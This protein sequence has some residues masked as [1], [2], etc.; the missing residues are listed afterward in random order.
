MP[1]LNRRSSYNNFILIFVFV[2]IALNLLAI[3]RFGFHRDELL[4][5]ALADYMDWGYKEVPPFIAFIAKTTLTIFGDSVFGARIIPTM[6]AALIV[7]LTGKLT[8]EMGGKKFAIALA[9]SAMIFSPSFASTGYLFQPVVFDQLWW[10]LL[11]W[12][13][14]R[15][16]NNDS[17]PKYLYFIGLV[18]G[19]GL[20]TK[21]TMAFFAGSVILGLLFTK[22]RRLL[23]N[24]HVIGA[25]ALALLI[26]LPNLIWQ[27]HH[28]WPV[29]GHM[30]EL[31]KT[32]L[33]F[34]QP[35]DFTKQQLMAHG[36]AVILWITG[37]FFLL[38][39]FKLR[40]FQFLGFAYLLI[41]L[42]LMEM[43]GKNYYL[44]GA[45]PMLFAAGG[46]GFDRWVKTV[47]TLRVAILLAFI[48]PNLILL[49]I[50]LP[51]LSFKRTLG[52]FDYINKHTE[53]LKS[54]TVWEDQQ[55]HAT[56]QDY[57]DMLGWDEMTKKVADNYNT[58]S[59]EKQRETIIYTTNYGEAGALRHL[60][61][62][63]NLPQ[64]VSLASS[65]A[66][67]APPDITA[68]YIIYVSDTGDEDMV[69]YRS[70][71]K[72]HIKLDSV[73]NTYAREKGTD[74]YLLE[75]KP[76]FYERYRQRF[77]KAQIW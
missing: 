22:Q 50:V 18:I 9:C 39:S 72:G 36:I 7:W 65:F 73:T 19:V 51:I 17:S 28:S 34:I 25:A 12:L 55:H 67:W 46:F 70:M 33:N 31:K 38:R 48:I 13:M 49:P 54:V 63:Y 43:N 37:L 57:A 11:V 30:A 35:L 68:R 62:Q 52:F 29:F 27:Y 56:T 58:F 64:S 40:K 23:W 6:C 76:E 60:G 4:H 2:K 42:F 74:I 71:L 8:V 24:K 26:F 47:L 77:I 69:Y 21:Y 53:V 75:P 1:Y 45:Y 20:L 3:S 15:Y 5:L 59:R 66:L 41:F 14:V 61:K 16:I 10:V 44:F 32:Q